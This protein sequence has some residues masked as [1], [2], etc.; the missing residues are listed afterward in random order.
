MALSPID[1]TDV[2]NGTGGFVIA[3]QDAGDWSGF[4]V[5]SAGDM[6]GDGLDDLI[7]GAFQGDAAGNA[8]SNAGESYVVFGEAGGFATNLDLTDVAAG[9]GG[10]VINGQEANDHAGYSVASAGDINGDGFDDLIIGAPQGSGAGNA[11][12]MAGESYVV[13]GKAGGYA[14]SIDL[15]SVAAGAGGFVIFGQAVISESGRSVASAGDINGD[16]FDDLIIGARLGNSVS[17]GR[18]SAGDSYVMFGKAARFAVGVDLKDVA[19]GT[20]GFVIFGQDAQDRSGT[21][22]ASAGDVNG[23]GFDDLIIGASNGSAAGNAKL[24]AG[25][26]YVVFGEAGS[27]RVNIDLTQVAAGTGGFV[28]NGQEATDHAGYSVASVGDI[29]GDGF[30][31]L[32]ISARFGDAAGNAKPGAGVSYVVFGK[33]GG[34]A[35]SIDLADVAAGIGGFVIFGQDARDNAGASVAAAGDIN[36]DGFD[37]LI[38]GANR[39]HAAG[40]T[41]AYAGDSYVVFGKAGGFGASVDL[42]TIAAG[43]GGFVIF[44]Q[45]AGDGSGTSVAPAGDTNGDGF[46]DLFI[47]ALGGG[48]AGNAKAA[49]GDSYVIFGKDF[50]NTVTHSGTSASQTLTGGGA[51]DDMVGGL[52]DDILLGNGGADVL[53]GGGGNDV[54]SVAD[55][56]FFRLDGGSGTDTLALSGSGMTLGLSAIANA[57]IQNIE[58]IDLT[59]TG[60]N[61]LTLSV[62]EVLNLSTTSNALKVDGDIGDAV[63]FGLEIWTEGGTSGGYTTYK[64]GQASVLVGGPVTASVHAQPPVTHDLSDLATIAAGTGGFVIHGQDGADMSGFSVASGRDVNGDGFDDLIIGA[65]HGSPASDLHSSAGDSYVVFGQASGFGVPIDLGNVAN[66]T[67]GFVI[68]GRDTLGQSGFSVA[69]AGDI[70]GDGFGDLIIGAPF[71]RVSQSKSYAGDSYVLFGKATGPGGPIDLSNVANGT[72]G[73]VIHA[74]DGSD[75]AGISVASAGDINGDG[76]DDLIIGASGGDAAGNVKD[77]AGDTYVIYGKASGFGAPIDLT[78][79]AAGAGG[80]VIHGRDGGDTSGRSV[81]S[82]GDING[83][84]YDDLM[85]GAPGGDAKENADSFALSATDAFTGATILDGP[86]TASRSFD[87]S[88]ADPNNVTFFP[89]VGLGNSAVVAF[90]TAPLT[91]AGITLFAGNDGAAFGFRRAMSAF[92]FYADTDNDGSYERLLVNQAINIDYN[93]GQAGVVATASGMAMTFQFAGDV[94]SSRWQ[95]EVFQGGEVGIFEGVRVQEID[96]ILSSPRS[97]AGDTYIVFGKGNGFGATIDLTNV[98]A[99][100]DGFVI[101]GQ[102]ANDGSGISV[103]SAGDIDG[104]GLTDLIIAA[105]GGDAAGNAKDGAGDSYVVY[106]RASG[107]AASIDLADVA[108]GTG[109][110]VIHG[111]DA[112]DGVGASVA[113]AGDINGDGLD[114]LIIGTPAAAGAG[115]VK[116]YTGDSYVLFGRA[117]GFGATVDLTDVAAGTGG[118]VIHG[119]DE[120]DH[121]LHTGS[122][123]SAGDINGDGF[124]D[125]IIGVA[126]GNA[127]GNGKSLSG[128][129]YVI[130]GQ[131]FTSTVTHAGTSASQTLTGS[132]AAD[133]M[134]AGLGDDTMFGNGGADVLIGGGGSD[135]LSV[136]DLNFRRLDGGSGTD[137]LALSGFGMTLDLSA[138]PDTRIQNIEAIDLTGTGGNTLNLSALEVLNLSTTSNTLRVDGNAGDSV[139]FGAEF[140]TNAGTSGGYMI[141]SRGQASLEVNANVAVL[142][143]RAGTHILTPDGKTAVEHLREGDIV[144]TH[145]GQLRPIVWIGQRHVDCQH[146]SEPKKILPVRIVAGAFGPGQPRTD[147]FLSPDHAIFFNGALIPVKHLIDGN[148]ITQVETD[149]VTYYHVELASHDILLAEGLPVESYLDTGDRDSFSNGGPFVRLFPAFG[150]ERDPN[151]NWEARGFAPLVVT[152]PAIEAARAVLK[153]WAAGRHPHSGRGQPG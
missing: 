153:R 11:R 102:D 84:G 6:N 123:A 2:A 28:I 15:A 43:T 117:G 149:E 37:D 144:K 93:S 71:A 33:A 61:T 1:L 122:V 24:G 30:D 136:A 142:C 103:A 109:G 21:S 35:A 75:S 68:E 25:E 16:G 98:A 124:D 87:G 52:G 131:D 85:I 135:V 78:D 29:N 17:N 145:G 4:A 95:Y 134:V 46:D 9:T 114:D 112:G 22:V 39:G 31:D 132:A 119:Q 86:S 138:I 67:G 82:A 20:G 107:F 143:F 97:N 69:S 41:K 110:F 79:V 100:T 73:F 129:S 19:A 5:A 128:D 51:A 148:S 150:S 104:D 74:Q 64:N 72:G 126:S 125:L 137:T 146:H 99:G 96:A 10:F 115:N 106:G 94:T 92:R 121:L 76:F 47:G 130:F 54:L 27:V 116:A 23:D 80:F 120:V 63:D 83:D 77:G 66:G 53:I 38:V 89:D 152:G 91:L 140:W 141:F 133:D 90:T 101:R 118:F 55:L 8:K 81:A 65:P 127:A 57:R 44:G 108:A 70:D 59:G 56:T 40:N 58:A 111:Q 32:I 12:F 139:D 62:L 34:F 13:F 14:A 113:S 50:T 147:L 105:W 48:G 151:L 3:G 18:T 88:D 42:T 26:S 45:D 49:A 60:D 7:I 36:G